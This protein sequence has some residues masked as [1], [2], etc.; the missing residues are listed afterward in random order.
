MKTTKEQKIVTVQTRVDAPIE[1]VW[2]LW[3]TPADIMNWCTGSDDWHTPGAENDLR[4]GGRFKTRME[5][6]KGNEGFDFE[7]VYNKVIPYEKIEYTIADGRKVSILFSRNL[8]KTKIV[9]TFEPEK[10]N[11]VELQHE[12]WQTI[13]DNFK[14]YTEV[15]SAFS[16]TPKVTH[17]ITPCLWF[18]NR[19]EEAVNFYI[20]V[21][22]DGKIFN[23][24]YYTKEGFEIHGQ[25][26]G[27][28][29]TV[30][31]Q[32]NGQRFTVLNGGPVFKFNESFSL[33]VFCGTQEDIDYYWNTLTSD[34]GEEGQCGW[35][36]DKY[37][38]SWQIIPSILHKLLTDPSKAGRVMNV[39]MPM[40]KLDIEKLRNA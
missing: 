11:T 39:L 35:L 19:A 2:K 24:S 30:D 6:K 32:L 14:R 16:K 9:E 27:T 22:R 20:S 5:A 17:Q 25:K 3:S 21:F 8:G 15:K 18:D 28:I 40:K 31:F 13:L 29:L 4:V 38:L 26:E 23:K 1:L 36:K 12:G 33:Q 7:G 10:E 37:G 34:G